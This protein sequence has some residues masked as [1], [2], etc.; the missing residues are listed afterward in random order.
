MNIEIHGYAIV[1]EDDRITDGSG[2]TPEVLRNQAD[3]AY[4]QRELDRADLVVLGRIGHEA[5]PN[6]KGRPRLVVSSSSS[7]LEQR[8]DAWWWNPDRSDWD[9]ATAR[10]LPGGGRV[11]VPGG[12]R[13]F[14]LF[15]RIGYAA[16]HLSR[17]EGVAIGSGT[18]LFSVC[19]RGASACAALFESGLEA[20][21]RQISR[22]RSPRELDR[23]DAL[24]GNSSYDRTL[25]LS[26]RRE[27]AL[28]TLTLA[29]LTIAGLLVGQAVA[30]SGSSGGSS[31]GS[32]GSGGSSS[33]TSSP[34][35]A[36]NAGSAGSP[37]ATGS[38]TSRGTASPGSSGTA[39]P[40]TSGEAKPSP[41]SRPSNATA[42]R[43]APGTEGSTGR[44]GGDTSGA[45][46][47]GTASF[48][49][50]A[51]TPRELE[52]RRKSE[53]IDRKVRRGICV[54]C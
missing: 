2:A 47:S 16:F 34:S 33:S 32:A 26:T 10:I 21:P 45:T 24:K 51:P 7:G 17:A 19:D 20:G 4:F 52:M 3:W 1:S 46:A 48:D 31:G 43:R 8:K 22:R 37:S 53:E 49:G 44:S 12:R 39:G 13:V 30:Q 42:P 14:D 11:A 5:N 38:P 36:G 15:L 6:T 35:G 40:T 9:E 27:A 29:T 25:V 41:G 50:P 18:S 54:G 23:V 28:R